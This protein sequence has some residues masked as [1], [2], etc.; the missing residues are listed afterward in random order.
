MQTQKSTS[1]ASA[2]AQA[3][4]E[5]WEIDPAGSSLEFTLRHLIIQEIRGVFH[6]WGGTVLIDRERPLRSRVEVSN[7]RWSPFMV[8]RALPEANLI[9]TWL[10]PGVSGPLERTS[11]FNGF[12]VVNFYVA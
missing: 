6:R 1:R 11:R 9:N 7:D 3:G 4:L 2:T 12:V 8:L 10:Q 5:R